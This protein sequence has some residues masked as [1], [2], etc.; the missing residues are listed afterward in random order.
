MRSVP[1]ITWFLRSVSVMVWKVRPMPIP[2]TCPP[3]GAM[4]RYADGRPGLV[5]GSLSGI[6]TSRI[7]PSSISGEVMR[8]IDAVVRPTLAAISV[9]DNGPRSTISS[10]TARRFR[11]PRLA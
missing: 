10:I 5:P 9:R 8:D 11:V 1:E 7:S 6:G 3:C 4:S 2:S